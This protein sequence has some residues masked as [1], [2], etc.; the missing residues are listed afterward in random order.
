MGKASPLY[1][2][3]GKMSGAIESFRDITA[4]KQTELDLRA[5]YD[6]ISATE[7]KL[8]DQYDKL[9]RNEQIL[10][11]SE[12][13]YR[14]LADMAQDLIYI[15]NKDDTITYINT[16]AATMMG[17]SREEIIG[18]SRSALFPGPEGESST[19]TCNGSSHQG[20]PFMKGTR[21]TCHPGLPG[22]TLT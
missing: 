20:C 18:K 4:S 9:S 22:R 12:E 21:F 15:I 17:M 11:T 1:D 14:T 13:K 10:R 19:G 8:R 6:E 2:R 7:E 3:Q 5:A 16:F